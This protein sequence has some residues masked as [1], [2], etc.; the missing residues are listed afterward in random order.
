MRRTI[1]ALNHTLEYMQSVMSC[2]FIEDIL[3]L[4]KEDAAAMEK[5]DTMTAGLI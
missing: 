4:L 5:V 1:D 2:N 3:T